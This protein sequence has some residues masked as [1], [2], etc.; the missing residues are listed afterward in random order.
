ME[1][2]II[3]TK[4]HIWS[5]KASELTVADNL[6][7]TGVM[8]AAAVVI[9]LGIGLAAGGAVT[10]Y[11]KIRNRKKDCKIVEIIKTEK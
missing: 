8:M 7:L 2:D 10:L 3:E 9:P 11:D 1:N 6:K 4:T 5:K